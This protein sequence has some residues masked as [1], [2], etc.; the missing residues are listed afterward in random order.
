MRRYLASVIACSA[1]L[2][3]VPVAAQPAQS[4][5]DV[6][7]EV[8][9]TAASGDKVGQLAAY[10]KL[11]AFLANDP[12][13]QNVLGLIIQ[14]DLQRDIARA[15]F[16]ISSEDACSA[17]ELGTAYL[18]QA[19]AIQ[20]RGTE[21]DEPEA[22]DDME[23]KL[24]KERRRMRCAHSG[25]RAEVGTPDASLA[26]HYYLSGVMET[27]SELLLKADGQFEWYISYGSVD[28]VAQGRWG[29]T[30]QTVTLAADVAA[31]DAPLFRADEVIPWD[32]D[33]ERQLRRFERAEQEAIIAARCPW[34][35]ATTTTL[36][37]YDLANPNPA[38]EAEL[39][40][41]S[42]AKLAAEAARDE[43]SRII[44]KAAAMTASEDER[45]AANV[46]MEMWFQAQADMA[47]AHHDAN[48]PEPDI[49]SPAVP[50]EC[51]LPDEESYQP[52][53]E[54]EW[55]RG[56]G[57]VIGDPAREMRL[58][59]VEVTFVFGDGHHETT[60]TR[61]GGFAFAPVRSR[62]AVEQIVLALSEP[63]SRSATLAIKPLP[64]GIQAVIVD[65]QQIVEPA[66]SVM[67]LDVEGENLIPKDMPRGRYSRN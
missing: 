26:G 42:E 34:S 45:A 64:E 50:P 44:A 12:N 33:A 58:S 39:A 7:E 46:A 23:S 27:G 49:G 65:T 61:Q 62:T 21:T 28:Q 16:A 66:F 48:L 59:H 17:L 24:S 40:K 3:L 6:V 8:E 20:A 2:A 5:S 25:P 29:R 51:Q 36:W 67:R 31:A 43:A 11:A 37:S 57:V 13:Q 4:A 38:G 1:C 15:A 56:V 41:A 10:Q 47:Q 9:R 53:P 30:G 60:K 32:G 14:A 52:I 63:V 18:D 55:R 19:R 54:S 35:I 22:I